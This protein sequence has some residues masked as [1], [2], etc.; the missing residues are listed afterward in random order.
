[1]FEYRR[2]LIFFFL[3]IIENIINFMFSVF[4]IYPK[5]DFQFKYWESTSKTAKKNFLN[6]IKNGKDVS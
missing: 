2:H 5:V 4:H 1:M 6:K 3:G